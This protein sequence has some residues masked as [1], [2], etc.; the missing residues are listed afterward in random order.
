M[1][2][3]PDS[4]KKKSVSHQDVALSHDQKKQTK[5]PYSKPYIKEIKIDSSEVFAPDGCGGCSG[6]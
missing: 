5:K 2:N 6:Y 4:K 1:S 3:T